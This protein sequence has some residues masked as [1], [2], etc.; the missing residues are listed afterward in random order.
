MIVW[1]VEVPSITKVSIRRAYLLWMFH[2]TLTSLTEGNYTGIASHPEVT[3]HG[4]LVPSASPF[5]K[6]GQ[7]FRRNRAGV[8][9]TLVYEL[10]RTTPQGHW[11]FQGNSE[12]V[13]E[14]CSMHL[15]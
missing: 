14:S 15:V 12:E 1:I 4:S 3:C 8:V 2:V 9:V 11:R 7:R 10:A 6:Q 13:Q 5:R